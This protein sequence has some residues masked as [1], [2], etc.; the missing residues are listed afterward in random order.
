MA[1]KAPRIRAD[2]LSGNLTTQLS[3]TP[4]DL[5]RRWYQTISGRMLAGPYILTVF[6]ATA[7][8]LLARLPWN[9]LLLLLL[10]P[11][12]YKRLRETRPGSPL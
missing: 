7:V 10:L 9:V 6:Y 2:G 11:S 1:Q 5:N 4:N 8:I 3:L 12:R